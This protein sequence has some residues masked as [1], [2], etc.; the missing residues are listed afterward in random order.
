[1]MTQDELDALPTIHPVYG[2]HFAVFQ[3]PDGLFWIEDRNGVSWFTGWADG[4]QYKRR[5]L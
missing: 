1:M 5:V 4:V 3:T 2:E